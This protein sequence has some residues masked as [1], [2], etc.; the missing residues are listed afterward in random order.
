MHH[1]AALKIGWDGLHWRF[2]Q[3]VVHSADL[4]WLCWQYFEA[5]VDWI[6]NAQSIQTVFLVAMTSWACILDWNCSAEANQKVLL[7]SSQS[8]DWPYRV[9]F[10]FFWCFFG[11]NQCFLQQ[12]LLPAIFHFSYVA[13]PLRRCCEPKLRRYPRDKCGWLV[14][15]C[16]WE[17][18]Y[19]F[20]C[21]Q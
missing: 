16:F 10:M 14:F 6:W 17:H 9:F 15:L 5:S 13:V 3:W 11:S 19:L 4:Y 18:F 1:G 7:H 2:F 12:S 20:W 8:S 21:C